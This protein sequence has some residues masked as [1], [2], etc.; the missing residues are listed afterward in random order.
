L[1]ISHRTA[2]DDHISEFLRENV[3]Y[4]VKQRQTFFATKCRAQAAMMLYRLLVTGA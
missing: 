2:S 3:R 4:G 1:F